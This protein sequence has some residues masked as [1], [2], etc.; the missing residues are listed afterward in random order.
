MKLSS[1]Y[2]DMDNSNRSVDFN[3]LTA[4]IGTGLGIESYTIRKP[5]K[6]TF[7]QKKRH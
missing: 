4:F 3:D 5:L 6:S 7:Q 2:D 1:L